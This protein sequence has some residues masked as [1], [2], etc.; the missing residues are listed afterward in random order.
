MAVKKLIRPSVIIHPVPGCGFCSIS[1]QDHPMKL[2]VSDRGPNN[3][4]VVRRSAVHSTLN[5]MYI[6]QEYFGYCSR[7]VDTY[8]TKLLANY[9]TNDRLYT[10]HIN[11]SACAAYTIPALKSDARDKTV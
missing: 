3:K 8:T 1:R 11:T 7:Y 5:D 6:F 2:T 10:R 9:I 4:P